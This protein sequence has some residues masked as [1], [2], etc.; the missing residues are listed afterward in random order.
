LHKIIFKKSTGR[1]ILTRLALT[2]INNKSYRRFY[3]PS[4]TAFNELSMYCRLKIRGLLS[5]VKNE[6]KNLHPMFIRKNILL[7]D[8]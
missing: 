7:R 6:R 4:I 8:T 2:L 5:I 1:E 3:G